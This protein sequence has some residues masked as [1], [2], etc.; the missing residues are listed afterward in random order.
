MQTTE[1]IELVQ[2]RTGNESTQTANDLLIAVLETLAE[3]D[4]DGAQHDFGAQLPDEYSEV[5]LHTDRQSQEAFDATEFV[6]R[7]ADRADITAGQAETWARATLSSLVESV[8][9]GERS[10]VV[11]ALPNDYAPYAKWDV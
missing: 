4:L 5:L 1:I 9:A 10:D 2:E 6:R 11:Q 3:L 7:V 8:T